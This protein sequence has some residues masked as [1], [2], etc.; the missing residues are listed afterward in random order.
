MKGALAEAIYFPAQCRKVSLARAL[1][2][3]L[4]H[5]GRNE[6]DAAQPNKW[7]V[8]K[9][10]AKDC[11]SSFLKN[12]SGFTCVSFLINFLPPV[13]L[14]TL[15]LISVCFG[16]FGIS[17]CLFLSSTFAYLCARFVPVKFIELVPTAEMQKIREA[18]LLL[19]GIVPWI[20]KRRGFVRVCVVV[21]PH[22][23]NTLSSRN[24]HISSNVGP[25]RCAAHLQRAVWG[26]SH[27]F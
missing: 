6:E 19:L 24:S 14:W 7:S 4:C 5:Y 11:H 27:G 12:N 16:P 20:S 10:E 13:F 2:A 21:C 17:L 3:L 25:F 23:Y 1:C 15:Q 9:V 26:L 18:L 8:R 22:I